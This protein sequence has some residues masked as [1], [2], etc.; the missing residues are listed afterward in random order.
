MQQPNNKHFHTLSVYWIVAHFVKLF[1]S[2]FT[3]VPSHIS[4]PSGCVFLVSHRAGSGPGT[5]VIAIPDALKGMII[6]LR[7]YMSE[8]Q[9]QTLTP[10]IQPFFFALSWMLHTSNAVFK[11]KSY[12]L[13]SSQVYCHPFQYL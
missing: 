2:I 12:F 8:L 10:Q 1:S 11:N 3:F 7:Y 5:L 13:K 9:W 4:L 6:S